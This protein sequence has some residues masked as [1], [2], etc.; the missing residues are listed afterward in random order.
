M[1]FK[2]ESKNTELNNILILLEF[3]IKLVRFQNLMDKY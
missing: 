3:M 2:G 1:W